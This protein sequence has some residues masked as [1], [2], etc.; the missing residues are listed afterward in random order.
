MSLACLCN[1]PAIRGLRVRISGDAPSILVHVCCR[2]WLV[3]STALGASLAIPS[4]PEMRLIMA[5]NAV[6]LFLFC[7]RNR[8]GAL[9]LMLVVAAVLESLGVQLPIWSTGT[10]EVVPC[11]MPGCG[12]K[13]DQLALSTST[14]FQRPHEGIDQEVLPSGWF[15]GNRE[16]WFQ[17][18]VWR[19][20]SASRLAARNR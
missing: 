15:S 18:C 9:N 13:R 19:R 20:L 6:L 1:T 5:C 10:L 16:S 11:P 8:V 4:R 12:M 7:G 14:S 17:L 3:C 2:K